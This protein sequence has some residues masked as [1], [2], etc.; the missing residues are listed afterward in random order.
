VWRI[1]SLIGQLNRLAS[2]QQQ[3]T[4]TQQLLAATIRSIR[5]LLAVVVGF[6]LILCGALLFGVYQ[7]KQFGALPLKDLKQI[8]GTPVDAPDQAFESQWKVSS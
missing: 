8:G 6:L 5:L 3:I 7:L 2:A 1:D 4:G